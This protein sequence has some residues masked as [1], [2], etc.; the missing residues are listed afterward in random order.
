MFGCGCGG[1]GN[2][3]DCGFTVVLLV[4]ELPSYFWMR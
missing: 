1:G 3:I 4:V 2:G